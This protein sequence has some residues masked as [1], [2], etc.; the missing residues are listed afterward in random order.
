MQLFDKIKKQVEKI[1]S[2]RQVL[3]RIRPTID[4]DTANLPLAPDYKDLSNWAA[5]PKFITKVAYTPE[6]I[7]PTTAWKDGQV[8]CFYVYPTLNFSSQYW[9]APLDHKGINELVDE[10]I[11]PGQV[12]V[13]NACCRIF[14]PRYRQATFYSFLRTGKNGRAALEVAG[15]DV[16]AAFDYYMANFNN[17]RPFFL[18]GHSQGSLHVMRLL[19]ERIEGTPLVK[20]LVA[21]YPI[22]FYFP[23]DKFKRTLKTIFPAHTPKAINCVVAW[24]TY[25]NT[26]GPVRILDRAEIRYN[27]NGKVRWE[28]RK[29]KE[30]LGVN[31]LKWKTTK[32]LIS[33]EHHL[34]GVFLFLESSKKMGLEGMIGEEPIGLSCVSLS[35]P[36]KLQVNAQIGKKG[37]LYVSKPK[38][39]AFR[40]L[41]LP[42]GYL[43]VF[44]I[45]LFYINLRVNIV[46]RWNAYQ[47]LYPPPN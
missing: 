37:F 1:A 7:K 45:A 34:G 32:E 21:A 25:L 24:D 4:F 16:V 28:K 38:Y 30:V 2:L 40:R 18:A 15:S 12:S 6:S 9:N 43:H 13:F 22:G 11:L 23:M 33:E 19:E 29:K 46:E 27:Q 47:E 35:K 41:M 10:L 20:Q 5:H 31:P 39:R 8:D 3:K 42:G 17:G 44:D 14:V 36:H 26:G